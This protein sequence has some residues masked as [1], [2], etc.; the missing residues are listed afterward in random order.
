MM[1]EKGF[2]EPAIC[3]SSAAAVLGKMMTL[4]SSSLAD[5][6]FKICRGLRRRIIDL[7]LEVLGKKKMHI[8]GRMDYLNLYFGVRC[9]ARIELF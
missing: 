9:F 5:N 7:H 8:G 3:S 4:K 6:L 2:G 1:C